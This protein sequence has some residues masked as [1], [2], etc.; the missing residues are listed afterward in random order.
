MAEINMAAS[1]KTPGVRRGKKLS[2]KVD[3][4]PM[5]D[6]GFL[7]ITFFVFTT[8]MGE[9]KAITLVN[10]KSSNDSM[11]IPLSTV[12][13]VF[14]L[15]NGKVFYYHGDF[16]NAIK[17]SAYGLSSYHVADGIGQVIRDKQAAMDRRKD[18]YSK[19]LFLIIKPTEETNYQQLTDMLDEVLINLLEHYAMSDIT[20]GEKEW[21]LKLNGSL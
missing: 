20:D 3:L 11:D 2:T 12:L 16:G 19:E 15:S 18:N 10:P 14:P 9:P 1:G 7:L 4:T 6:L 5:V 8:R 13:T 17:T 21:I